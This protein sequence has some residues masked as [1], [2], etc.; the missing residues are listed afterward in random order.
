[1][2]DYSV[3]AKNRIS[4]IY[5]DPKHPGSFGSIDRLKRSLNKNE[6]ISRKRISDTLKKDNTY[7]RHKRVKHKFQR[8]KVVVPGMNY[9][10]QSDL[11]ILDKISKQNSNYSAILTTIDVFSK[12]AFATAIKNKTAE[13]VSS[14]LDTLFSSVNVIPKYL[15]TDFGGEFV[16]KKVSK[17]LN[18]YNVTLYHNESPFKACVVERFNRSLMT[19][20]SKYMHSRNTKRYVNVLQDV[21]TSYNNTIHSSTKYK[22][23]DVT[24]ENEMNVFINLYKTIYDTKW[25]QTPAF[26][27]GQYVHIKIIKEKFDKGYSP[28]FSSDTFQIIEVVNSKPLTYKVVRSDGL[29]VRGIF[30]KEELIEATI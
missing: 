20:L 23:I 10:W 25:S 27:E 29:E 6:F 22:P 30:Y 12:Y 3:F 14:S 5:H 13:T 4:S 15:Q 11:I 18:K 1:M 28:T 17:V 21:V 9:L 2:A 8:R 19:R 7:A 26:R 24:K 16:N